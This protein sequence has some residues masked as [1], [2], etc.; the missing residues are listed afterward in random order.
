MSF[1]I[2]KTGSE[3]NINVEISYMYNK[4]KIYKN[5]IENTLPNS[6]YITLPYK[7]SK[8]DQDVIITENS[9]RKLYN[10]T[11]IY[12]SKSSNLIKE[13][14]YDAE[15]LIKHQSSDESILYT[16]FY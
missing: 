12:I 14:S 4:T 10:T 8:C 2:Y 16:C 9:K 5:Q 3:N 7:C 1:D 11:T 13:L 15:L 6:G